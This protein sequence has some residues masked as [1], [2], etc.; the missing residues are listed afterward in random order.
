MGFHTN[1][2]SSSSVIVSVRG[3]GFAATPCVFT[4]APD[5]V[6]ALFNAS[7]LFPSAVRVTVPV[8]RTRPAAT[9]SVVPSRAKSSATAGLT[10]VADNVTVVSS[11]DG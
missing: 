7:M 8:L 6:T 10:A 9:L 3:G 2:R 5:T 4:A 1:P 11:L